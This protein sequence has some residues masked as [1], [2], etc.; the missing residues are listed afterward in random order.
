VFHDIEE[1]SQSEFMLP[2]PSSAAILNAT[3]CAVPQGCFAKTAQRAGLLMKFS[4]LEEGGVDQ[5][6]SFLFSGLDTP[7][8]EHSGLHLDRLDAALD[9]RYALFPYPLFSHPFSLLINRLF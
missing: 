6:E 8:Y 7:L 2:P 1:I 9:Q 4:C 3:F 5:N